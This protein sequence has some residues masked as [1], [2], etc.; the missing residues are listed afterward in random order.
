M[1]IEL[2]PKQNLTSYRKLAIASWRHPRDP[3]TYT[4]L[5]LPVAAAEA[6]L[7]SSAGE[8]PLT[9]THYVTKIMGHCFEAYP[10]LNHVL[11]RGNL[12]PRKSVD[13]F[14]TTLLSGSNGKDLSGFLLRDVSR[15]SIREIAGRSTAA[16]ENLRNNRDPDCLREQ[17][18]VEHLPTCILRPLVRLQEFVQFTLNRKLP[19]LGMTGDRYGS[20]MI[21][22]VGALGI[23]SA[24]IPLSPYSRCPLFIGIG[25]PRAI[26]VVQGENV[27]PAESVLITFTFDHRYADG[28]H[29]ARLLRRFQKI[30]LHPADYEQVFRGSG[31]E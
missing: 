29:C 9:L 20:L 16:A 12:Y 6:F 19:F 14:V 4:S 13:V 10:E 8:D 3:S 30:F 28:A 27:I 15:K 25:K 5:D 1:N 18:F 7:K 2:G 22:N 21:S 11:R 17:R 31:P 24:Y 26:P 23:E